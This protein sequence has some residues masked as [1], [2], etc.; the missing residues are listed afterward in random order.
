MQNLLVILYKTPL[1]YDS[2]R[3]TRMEK[4]EP[5]LTLRRKDTFVQDKGL[6]Q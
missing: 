2:D 1:N 3:M 6:C 5:P 4:F